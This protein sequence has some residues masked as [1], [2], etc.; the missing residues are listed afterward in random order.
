M[1]QTSTAKSIMFAIVAMGIVFSVSG[2]VAGQT[3]MTAY[4]THPGHHRNSGDVDVGSGSGNTGSGSDTATAFQ[5]TN[6]QE[7]T[8]NAACGQVVSGVVNLTANLNCSGDGLIVGGPN[9]VINMN[10]F[11]ITGPGQDS[12]KVGIMVPNVDNVVVNGPGSISNFQAGY[13]LLEQLD[14]RLIL[15]YYL[16]TR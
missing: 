11:S 3:I 5:L 1:N 16:T 6:T 9:T 15:S 8:S 12:S 10:G 4:A 13:F 14:L 7:P 2:L